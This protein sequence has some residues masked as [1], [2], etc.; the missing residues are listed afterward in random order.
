[1]DVYQCQATEMC[2]LLPLF[3]PCTFLCKYL[4]PSVDRYNFQSY[5]SNSKDLSSTFKEK[6]GFLKD[7]GLLQ[8]GTS[9]KKHWSKPDVNPWR[10]ILG[11]GWEKGD[12]KEEG[13]RGQFVP[14]DQRAGCGGL[15]CPCNSG[16]N[17]WTVPKCYILVS[18]PGTWLHMGCTCPGLFR[19]RQT[20]L[21][22][23]LRAL[24][25]FRRSFLI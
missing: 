21:D 9:T 10:P 22:W 12:L 20:H 14:G 2:L 8:S 19:S 11:Q 13:D 18:L 23:D 4:S 17:T 6:L 25:T 5:Q 15:D 24:F 3:L 1:M 7:M 16:E